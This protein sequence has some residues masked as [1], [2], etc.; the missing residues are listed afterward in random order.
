MA[1]TVQWRWWNHSLS[2]R[3]DSCDGS[4]VSSCAFPSELVKE[5]VKNGNIQIYHPWKLKVIKIISKKLMKSLMVKRGY[6]SISYSICFWLWPKQAVN[7]DVWGYFFARSK[8][9]KLKITTTPLHTWSFSEQSHDSNLDHSSWTKKEFKFLNKRY[10]MWQQLEIVTF[11][12]NLCHFWKI[13][14]LM[15]LLFHNLMLKLSWSTLVD[16]VVLILNI[17]FLYYS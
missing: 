13:W 2:Q 3:M 5:L 17:N 7:D 8:I 4:R 9:W 14:F 1:C 6:F 11:P 10:L 15:Q 12:W 16:Q